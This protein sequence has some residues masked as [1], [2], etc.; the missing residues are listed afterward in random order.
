M[1]TGRRILVIEENE[2]SRAHIAWTIESVGLAVITVTSLE[3]AVNRLTKGYTDLVII[4][5]KLLPTSGEEDCLQLLKMR[6]V[7]VIVVGAERDRAVAMLEAGADACMSMPLNYPELVARVQSLLRR[8]NG[9]GY[10]TKRT[11]RMSH[12][13]RGT[14]DAVG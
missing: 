3:E 4:A 6:N 5:D 8:R 7:S 1:T 2:Q 13:K 14:G 10:R 12:S 9:E 11:D